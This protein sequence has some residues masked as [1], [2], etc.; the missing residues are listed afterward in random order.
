MSNPEKASTSPSNEGVSSKLMKHLFEPVDGASL[1]F[2]RVA[3]G[4]I[5]LWETWRYYSNGWISAFWIEPGFHF[6]YY[7]LDWI[8]P[9]PGIGMYVHFAALAVL[10]LFVALG[11][12]YRASI[13]LFCVGFTYVFLLDQTAYQNHFYLICLMSFLMIFVPANRVF[14]LDALRNPRGDTVPAWGVWIL[15]FQMGIVYFFGAIAKLNGDWLRGEPMTIWLSPYAQAFSINEST[16]GYVFS[17]GGLFFDFLIV[18]LLLWERTRQA[19]FL[20]A[21]GFHLANAGLFDIG[22]FPFFAIAA[23]TLFLD[24]SWPRDL[25]RSFQRNEEGDDAPDRGTASPSSGIELLGGRRRVV[26]GLLAVFVAFQV[27]VP[28][29]HFLYPGNVNWGNEGSRFAWHMKIRDIYAERAVFRAEFANGNSIVVEPDYLLSATQLARLT[30]YPDMVLR[31][32]HEM[33]DDLREQGFGEV[34]IH[35]EVDVS[36]NGREA[37]PLVYPNLDLASQPRNLAP[38]DWIVPLEEPLEAQAQGPVRGEPTPP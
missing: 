6:T 17:Y 8:Q 5:M 36:L 22:I 37:Q 3:F 24:P 12:F 9:W 31:T 21:T 34:E 25:I 26:V 28:L 29:R 19:A 27:L 15:C 14:S 23:T 30:F 11:L 7:G 35:A 1:A 10:A 16:L 32:A 18:P 33:A 13:A 38:A 4:L 20:L 2:F